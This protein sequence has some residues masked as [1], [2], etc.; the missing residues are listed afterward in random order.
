MRVLPLLRDQPSLALKGGTAIN[1]F[2]QDLPRLSVDIDLSY[3]GRE[4]R[5]EALANI[6]AALLGLRVGLEG[7][8]LRV[9]A[10]P[11][12]GTATWVKLVVGGGEAQVKVE[13]SPVLRGTVS[14]PQVRQT[15]PAVQARF[16]FAEASVLALPELYAGKLVAALDRQH[17]RDL[18]DVRLLLAQGELSRETLLAFLVYLISHGR[19]LDEVLRPNFKDLAAEF[20]RAFVG[21][22]VDEVPLAALEQAR[23]Q[24]V[25]ELHAGLTEQDRAFL[26]GVAA[27]E[28][29]WGLLPLQGVAEL[30]AVRW[31]LHNIAQMEAGKRRAAVSKLEA[32]LATAPDH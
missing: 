23:I 1:L 14:A 11:L 32:A 3:T 12:R 24:L 5:N 7:L 10:T 13:V 29:D 16:G 17:P 2:V 8:G 6:H 4:G 21:M 27:G 18:Y 15:T 22:T 19:P 30:P 20:N 26:L 25:N 9:Q 31:K 28:P